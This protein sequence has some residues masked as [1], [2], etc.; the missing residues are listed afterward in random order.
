MPPNKRYSEFPTDAA[1]KEGTMKGKGGMGNDD[2]RLG[3][4]EFSKGKSRRATAR[5][6]SPDPNAGNVH[7][8]KG[9]KGSAEGGL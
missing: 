8:K 6:V 7:L 4:P 2:G 9:G 1:Q 3:G 5:P